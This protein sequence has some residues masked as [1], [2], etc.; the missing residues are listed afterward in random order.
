[1]YVFQRTMVRLVGATGVVASHEGSVVVEV[2]VHPLRGPPTWDEGVATA[3]QVRGH[4]LI[5]QGQF[6][7]LRG[8]LK[9]LIAT[10][11]F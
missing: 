6:Q 10:S 4:K 5:R 8:H 7:D 9:F 2:G 1:M 3:L 11:Y